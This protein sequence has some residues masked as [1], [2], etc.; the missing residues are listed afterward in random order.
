MFWYIVVEA[1]AKLWEF[2][3]KFTFFENALKKIVLTI[4]S[5]CKVENWGQSAPSLLIF[6]LHSKLVSCGRL[7]ILDRVGHFLFRHGRIRQLNAGVV[8]SRSRNCLE[9]TFYLSNCLLNLQYS[10][11]PTK[12]TQSGL[13]PPIRVPLALMARKSL[14]SS[15]F[16]K[17]CVWWCLGCCL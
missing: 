14:E 4:S 10:A 7:K 15:C 16:R 9:Y 11:T 12:L 17:W 3:C 6:G 1:E 2:K 8:E 13:I 5:G